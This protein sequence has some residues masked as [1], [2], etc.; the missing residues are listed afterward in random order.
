MD[1]DNK[2]TVKQVTV[3]KFAEEQKMMDGKGKF[4]IPQATS[5]LNWMVQ[6][7]AAKVIGKEARPVGADGK[8]SVGK[9]ATIFEIPVSKAIITL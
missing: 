3:R 9:Q 4:N 6:K 1:T 2:I 5:V 7:G 8:P